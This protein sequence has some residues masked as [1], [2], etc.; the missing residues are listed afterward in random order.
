ARTATVTDPDDPFSLILLTDTVTV[1]GKVYKRSYDAATKTW[2]KISPEGRQSTTLIDPQGR[3]LTRHTMGLEPVHYQYDNHGRLTEATTGQG[4][5]T[6]TTSIRYY[7]DGPNKGYV[8]T[9]TDA[10]GRT[11]EYD[12]DLAGRVVQQ[13][14]PD[15][16]EIAYGYDANGNVTEIVPPDQPPHC[17]DYTPL[18]QEQEYTP[19][20]LGD[21]DPA[22]RYRY[23]LDKQLTSIT[24][25]DG[26]TVEMSYTSG[27]QL[28]VLRLPNGDYRY[29]Y[30][31]ATGQLSALTAP[32]GGSV[33]VTYDGFLPKA[34]TWAGEIAGTVSRNYTTD[35]QVRELSVNAGPI[36]FGYD[37]DGL[38]TQAGN[39]TL[40]RD[41]QHG[42]LSA[43]ALGNTATALSY[44]GFGEISSDKAS[45]NG[46]TLYEV[47]YILD[48]LGRIIE[49]VETIDGNT[50]TTDY[51]YD[52]AGRLTE[53]TSN[54]ALTAYSFDANG[55][56]LKKTER[57]GAAVIAETTATYD[58]QD[59]LLQY[60]D[61]RYSYT[62][63]GELLTKT[64]GTQ[65]TTYDY[66]VLGNLRAVTLPEGTRIDYL[67]DGQNRRIGKKVNGTLMQG[68][69][70]QD[71]LRPIAELD[72]NN[73]VVSRF[74]YADKSNV[75]AYMIKEG[76]TYRIVSD[77]LG[78][79]RLVI[80]TTDGTVVQR[81]D[82]D[83][84]G[85]VITD[86]KPG[87]QPFRF[88][89]GLYDQHTK[90]VRF[91]ARDYDPESGRWTAKD[92]IRFDSRLEPIYVCRQ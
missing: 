88:A 80:N 48:R 81:M 20:E 74:V 12:Y 8:Q 7:Q 73:N 50:T 70:Y 37:A 36:A 59:R 13:A 26:Q 33:S 44:N 87:F 30:N 28:E 82:Y 18:D 65:T 63:N 56:R 32:D 5:E 89:G 2:M 85:N 92:P 31:P 66:D 90:L 1:N 57:V 67:I 22:T 40:A 52:P 77:H 16:R 86:T 23:N 45:Y 91:G 55:N 61:T 69:L 39:M 60:G 4:A 43:S 6:R 15:G 62:P 47:H 58:A 24:R 9:L 51:T 35:F 17:F 78:S 42:L 72:G 29:G 68:F 75:P 46:N 19:P 10:L 76:V 83:E 14:L 71:Q 54:G 53:V 21:G 49:K 64:V 41:A 79:P 27:G 34:T 25:P 84:F 11:V 3:P 38:L